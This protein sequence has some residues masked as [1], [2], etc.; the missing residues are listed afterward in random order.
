MTGK[1]LFIACVLTSCTGGLP[2]GAGCREIFLDEACGMRN[3]S[4]VYR[5]IPLETGPDNLIGHISKTEIVGERIFV[6]DMQTSNSLQVYDINGAYITRIG[7]SGNGPGEYVKPH[8]FR[9]DTAAQTVTV[10]DMIQDRLFLYDL[11]TYQYLSSVKVPFYFQAHIPLPGGK[12]AWYS[13]APGYK[14]ARDLYHLQITDSLFRPEA[15]HYPVEFS[16]SRAVSLAPF[17]N[18]YTYG[19]RTCVYFPFSPV[20]YAISDAG[21][22]PVYRLRFGNHPFPSPDDRKSLADGGG[23]YTRRLLNSAYVAAWC[24]FETDSFIASVYLV[25][26]RIHAGIYSKSEEKTYRYADFSA[27][28]DEGIRCIELPFTGTYRD[29]FI[30]SISP[31][32]LK[33]DIRK[34]KRP[35]FHA[36]AEKVSE[37]DNPVLCLI[38]FN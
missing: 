32:I 9:I 27:G 16:S 7:T 25:Q 11:N 28:T 22:T 29:Y 20:V 34:I 14:K 3:V 33:R 6:L 2:D 5:F 10:E 37:E 38:K 8:D 17:R 23:D 12:Q 35:D 1:W 18:F 19:G 15:H 36:L 21:L 24:V 4:P 26:N 31:D 13:E 30:A